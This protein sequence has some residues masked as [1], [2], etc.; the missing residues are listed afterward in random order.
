MSDDP[1]LGDLVFV[2][3]TLRSGFIN[4]DATLAFRHGAELICEGWLPGL[5]YSTGWYPAL[6]EEGPGRVKGEVWKLTTPGTMHVLD[7]YEGI[8]EVPPEYER[9]QRD[10]QT[11]R[12]PIQAWVYIYNDD[13]DPLQQI[14]SGDWADAFI[15]PGDVTL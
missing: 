9:V 13:V 5:L 2:Y 10:V 7:D 4:N 14:P 11:S 12:G 3:G 6:K 8:D 1:H 15:E